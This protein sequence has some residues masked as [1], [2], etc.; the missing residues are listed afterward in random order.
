MKKVEKVLFL[1]LICSTSCFQVFIIQSLHEQE[2]SEDVLSKRK[3]P[4]LTLNDTN[5][6][7]YENLQ[8]NVK[9]NLKGFVGGFLENKGQ[10]NEAIYYYTESS[11]IAVGFG[12]SEIRFNIIHSEPDSL[13]NNDPV[14]KELKNHFTYT[15]ISLKFLGSNNIIPLV[16]GPTGVY[17]NYFVRANEITHAVS[18]QYY[19]KVIYFNIYE[20]IDLIYELKDS[21]LKYEFFV[22]PGGKIDDIKLNWIGPVSL[23]LIKEGIKVTVRLFGKPDNEFS[24]TD[25][26][27]INYQSE[28]REKPVKGSF[29]ILGANTYGFSVPTFDPNKLLI[30]DPI[31]QYS[32]YIS[33]SRSDIGKDIAIDDAGNVYITGHTLSTDFPPV[34]AYNATGDGS[35]S[36]NDVFV[37]KLAADGSTLLYS[38]YVSGSNEDVGRGIAVDSAGN[39]Y[40]TGGTMSTDFPTVNAYNATGDGNINWY[41]VFVFK[42]AADGSTLLYS[43]YV[44]GSRKDN[45]YGIAIDVAGNAY[46]TGATGSTDFPTVNA[47]D[48]TGDIANEIFVFKLNS[49]GNGLLYST[50]VG[51]SGEDYGYGIAV[52][53]SGNTY[54][55]GSTLSTDFPTVNAYDDTGDGSYEDGFVFKLRNDGHDLLYSTYVGGSNYDVGNGIVIDNANNAYVT[56]D[57][58]SI[59]FPTVNAY[60]ATGDGSSSICD[61]FVFKLNSNGDSMAYSTYISGSDHDFG[62][63]IAI[64][65]AGNVHVSGHTQSTDFPTITAYDDIKDGFY[66]AFMF[67][68]D[69]TGY[70]LVY[71]TFVGGTHEDVGNGIAVDNTGN[72]FLTGYTRST[73]FPTLNAYDATGDGTTSYSDVFAFKIKY[74]FEPIY[75][76]NNS[77]FVTLGFPGSGTQ[78]NPYR[79]EGCIIINSTTNLIYIQDTTSHFI[80]SN[81]WLNGI[82]GSFDGIRISNVTNGAIQNNTIIN[83]DFGIRMLFD[84]KNN[85]IA[86]NTIYNSSRDGLCL[87]SSSEIIIRNNTLYNNSRHGLQLS[88]NSNTNNVS[89]NIIYNNGNF[90]IELYWNTNNTL[91]DN[92]I[93]GNTF[94]GI[95]LD[96][97]TH[98]NII[99]N[100][101]IY[102]NS[103][104]GIYIS[105]NSWLNQIYL[106][107]ILDNIGGQAYDDNG[108]S[109]FYYSGVGNY[110]G[111]TY[112][113]PD[114]NKDGVGDTPYSFTGNQDPYPL[115]FSSEIYLVIEDNWNVNSYEF[116]QN[117]IITLSGNLTVSF[118]GN[119]TLQNVILRMNCDHD[120]QCFVTVGN[121]SQLSIISNSVVTAINSSH[122]WYLGADSGSIFRLENSTI[123]YAGWEY[124]SMGIH[125]GIWINTNAAI[126]SNNTIF[127]NY[128]GICL[129]QVN[130]LDI[131]RNIICNNS[132]YGVYVYGG[133][134]HNFIGNTICNNTNSGFYLSTPSNILI[135]NNT[136]YMNEFG[137]RIS[138]FADQITITENLFFNHSNYGIQVWESSE[139]NIF[140]NN[141]I[142]YSDVAAIRIETDNN[143]V[144]NN[145][146]H[147]INQFSQYGIFLSSNTGN[148][149]I[150]NTI[151]DT[152]R[153]I[154]LL[155][156]AFYNN[157]SYNKIS[158]SSSG[159]HLVGADHN[160]IYNNTIQD[161]IYGVYFDSNSY[162][163]TIELNYIYN[164]S[165]H[166]LYVESSTYNIFLQ[167]HLSC[168]YNGYGI[169]I[170]LNSDHNTILENTVTQSGSHGIV[171]TNNAL[172]NSVRENTVH[173][174]L[175]SGIYLSSY[176]S[177]NILEN[178]VLFNNTQRGI[179][180][181][182][183]AHNNTVIYNDIYYNSYSG[184]ELE[185]CENN[186]IQ[187]NNIT[188]NTMYGIRLQ[189]STQNNSFLWNLVI[190]NRQGSIQAYDDGTDNTFHSNYWSDH[191]TPDISPV[192]GFVDTPYT[193]DGSIFNT[194]DSPRT[195]PYF[196]H[197]PISINNNTDFITLGFPGQG[198]STDPYVIENYMFINSTTVLINIQFTTSHFII[199]NCLL[200][201]IN[202]GNDGIYLNDVFF[203]LIDNNSIFNSYYAIWLDTTDYCNISRN[204]VYLNMQGIYLG[205]SSNNSVFNNSITNNQGH[206]IYLYSSEDN[207]ISSNIFSNNN[208]G[209]RFDTSTFNTI[210]DNSISYNNM[211]GIHLQ[212]SSSNNDLSSNNIFNNVESGIWLNSSSSY[213]VLTDNIITNN[214]EYGIYI[215]SCNNVTIYGNTID[216]NALHGIHIDSTSYGTRVEWNSFTNNNPSGGSQAFDDETFLQ[217]KFAYNHWDDWLL[218]DNNDGMV[219][220][221]YT[222]EGNANNNDSFPLTRPYLPHI[223]IWIN[224]NSDFRTL[225]FP[226]QGTINNPYIIEGYYIVNDSWHLIEIQHTTAYFVIRNC[227]I[228]P[229]NASYDG[230]S[231]I[232]VSYGIIEHNLI[233]NGTSGITLENSVYNIT[234][235]NN[236]IHTHS[237]RGIFLQDMWSGGSRVANNTV[238]YNTIF[239]TDIG[240][241]LLANSSNNIITYNYIYNNSDVGIYVTLSSDNFIYN[242]T[243]QNNY[244]FLSNSS[245]NILV[246]NVVSNGGVNG[247]Q[248]SFSSYNNTVANNTIFQMY[249]GIDLDYASWNNSIVG[250]IIFNNSNCGIFLSA[251][252]NI[253]ITDNFIYNNSNDGIYFGSCNNCIISYNNVYNNSQHGIYLWNSTDVIISNNTILTNSKEG[254]RLQS[255][256]YNTLI[257]NSISGNYVY[258]L[259]LF[260]SNSSTI[261]DNKI[262]DNHDTGIWVIDSSTNNTIVG[263]YISFNTKYGI[264]F[265]GV[266]VVYNTIENNT[267]YYNSEC[268][269]LFEHINHMPYWHVSRGYILCVLLC[270][271]IVL[272][273]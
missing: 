1:F 58:F 213:N 132:E 47:Y 270:H 197:T 160:I 79:I 225:G 223:P 5:E 29:K 99:K 81:N 174:C 157:I 254:I 20:K 53:T 77:D 127:G 133:T 113:G 195:Y 18:C 242:N 10:K 263:N 4:K 16:K 55:T 123:S 210:S 42:L 49:S 251:V 230:I 233:L 140:S 74:L 39:A 234:V 66:D 57:T 6:T 2:L 110:W 45:G 193:I 114:V 246:D 252:N 229:L 43:T 44:S 173:F 67:M 248:L 154:Y 40:V 188:T 60:N 220:S 130:N 25:T 267:I 218:D 227:L 48:D 260:Y 180:L 56:G 243:L 272:S 131:Q 151:Y 100:N 247:I 181:H 217:N 212:T 261:A 226:G 144:F 34:N 17:N 41:D 259:A 92:K 273:F 139:N 109:F 21:Q 101:T 167:N 162:N 135:H 202:K 84:S 76:D 240:I 203:G 118:P 104:Y 170:F 105:N 165:S 155:S 191:T 184:I 245:N 256:A 208:Y 249:N 93:Y 126:I 73:D 238:S 192:D 7:G 268:G 36:Y 19:T 112:S 244:L 46:V 216:G 179:H 106:N 141:T 103:Q 168:E 97:L 136:I 72:I 224:D 205:S 148:D 271:F 8:E 35:T 83:G 91:Y 241:A 54:V 177:E 262:M 147:S 145:T 232:N 129:Y 164:S 102:N 183:W 219:D 12:T 68:L 116:H 24:F 258:G 138:N 175:H 85:T 265:K 211:N 206:G 86:Y 117:E 231:L 90:G 237:L 166:A 185:D 51:G 146:I 26:S 196:P 95:R 9:Y 107:N 30:I 14:D 119:L 186:T 236:T 169:Y 269:I 215:E 200:N 134:N 75:I 122:A 94:H 62:N 250:N 71:S 142:K 70:R 108:T 11:Q 125:T 264:Y 88:L 178:N 190:T 171:I 222:I 266:S 143:L 87:A 61:V 253:T 23:N 194:D 239:D 137:V 152:Y 153:G 78:I 159:V 52:D 32:T 38:T 59:D 115:L 176:A 172:N 37:F 3:I 204:S 50:Y 111:S 228:N 65:E 22:H 201:G 161:T 120:G 96:S 82:N 33:G 27:P 69:S 121:S 198:T 63:G 149:I 13:K 158:T 257:N 28:K 209:V 156:S 214:G 89:N 124:G 150:N 182:T 98:D 31:L 189:A 221:P 80:I 15:T 199:R 207:N 64:D 163:N 235:L 128:Y 187:Y 255:T